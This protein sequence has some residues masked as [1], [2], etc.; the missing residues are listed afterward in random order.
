MSLKRTI[1]LTFT[2]LGTGSNLGND[3]TFT[4]V[5]TKQAH[6]EEVPKRFTKVEKRRKKRELSLDRINNAFSM[7]KEKERYSRCYKLQPVPA[8]D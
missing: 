2:F 6:T 4:P 3:Q 5:S 7:N 8:V 1:D